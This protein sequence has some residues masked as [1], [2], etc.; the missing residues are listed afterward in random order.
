MYIDVYIYI[1]LYINPG[2]AGT[3]KSSLLLLIVEKLIAKHGKH[4]VFITATTGLAACA[5]SG[6]TVHQ[7]AGITV[8]NNSQISNEIEGDINKDEMVKNA[9]QK[10]SIV[11]RLRQARVLIVDEVSMMSPDLLEA[12][13]AIAQGL[14]LQIYIHVF[15]CMYLYIFRYICILTH[16]YVHIYIYIYI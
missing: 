8:S 1:Y 6:T 12:L 16:I 15:I 11:R 3:G 2:G 9:L 5:I 4:T 14:Y 13:N 10:Q 7:F